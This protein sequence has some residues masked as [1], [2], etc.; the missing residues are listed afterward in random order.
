MKDT[1]LM[2]VWCPV[3]FD[4]AL[5]GGIGAKDREEGIVINEEGLGLRSSGRY[6]GLSITGSARLSLGF[7]VTIHTAIMLRSVDLCAVDYD[8]H[9]KVG[10]KL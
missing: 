2:E 9:S 3:V 4:Q 1:S 5:E 6:N 7:G 10:G 8:F